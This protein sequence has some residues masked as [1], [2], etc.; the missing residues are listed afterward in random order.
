MK[1]IINSSIMIVMFSSLISCGYSACD[2]VEALDFVERTGGFGG[3]PPNMTSKAAGQCVRDYY[4][5]GTLGESSAVRSALK[6]SKKKCGGTKDETKKNFNDHNGDV[7][8][9]ALFYDQSSGV[10]QFNN[11]VNKEI[12]T[13]DNY[14]DKY[15]DCLE[16]VAELMNEN[17]DYDEAMGSYGIDGYAQL[18]ESEKKIQRAKDIMLYNLSPSQCSSFGDPDF[19]DILFSEEVLNLC[20]W[21]SFIK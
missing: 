14:T 11:S 8:S 10:F 5:S 20:N 17:R 3:T 4:S 6:N 15:C 13:L 19:Y 1:K 16:K 18:S 12:S 9:N 21:S 2:C 7:Q